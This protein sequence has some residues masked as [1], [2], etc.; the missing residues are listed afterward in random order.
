[1]KR[2]NFLFCVLLLSTLNV[3]IVRAA[4]P[5]LSV[6]EFPAI[7]EVSFPDGYAVYDSPDV[8]KPATKRVEGPTTAR[9]AAYADVPSGRL[10]LS[11]WSYERKRQGQSYFW[12]FILGSGTPEP[13]TASTTNSSSVSRDSV[14]PCG[15]R[16][17]ALATGYTVV[18]APHAKAKLLK[19]VKQGEKMKLS[20]YLETAD[21]LYFISDWSWDR[22]EK[23]ASA[24]PNWI[25]LPDPESAQSLK[26]ILDA[27]MAEGN[28]AD[29]STD[30]MEGIE[31]LAYPRRQLLKMREARLPEGH[32]ERLAAIYLLFESEKACGNITRAS[33]LARRYLEEGKQSDP[34]GRHREIGMIHFHLRNFREADRH[35]RQEYPKLIPDYW[36]APSA[37][38]LVIARLRSGGLPEDALVTAYEQRILSESPSNFPHLEEIYRETGHEQKAARLVVSAASALDR[39]KKSMEAAAEH[40]EV[41]PRELWK[42]A[43]AYQAAGRETEFKEML[44]VAGSTKWNPDDQETT[45]DRFDQ[46][47]PL[48]CLAL[49]AERQGLKK[50]QTAIAAAGMDFTFWRKD[51]LEHAGNI[52]DL[53]GFMEFA[54]GLGESVTKRAVLDKVVATL[55]PDRFIVSYDYDQE[56]MDESLHCDLPVLCKDGLS[57]AALAIANK[58]YY[59][60]CH[61]LKSRLSRL[62]AEMPA[63]KALVEKLKESDPWEKQDEIFDALRKIAGANSRWLRDEV[64]TLAEVQKT[65]GPGTALVDFVRVPTSRYSAVVVTHAG[66][67]VFLDLGEADPINELIR[68]YREIITRDPKRPGDVVAFEQICRDLHRLLAAPVEKAIVPGITDLVI[69][70]DDQLH[71]LSFATLLGETGSMWV[72]SR[73]ICYVASSRDLVRSPRRNEA[74]RS[75]LLIGNPNYMAN[76]PLLALGRASEGRST[77]EFLLAQND[78]SASRGALEG[79]RLGALPGTTGEVAQLRT[80]FEEQQITVETWMGAHADEGRLSGIKGP[81]IL[82]LATHGF[83]FNELSRGRAG[84]LEKEFIASP[85]ERAGVAVA[86]AQTTIHLWQQGRVPPRAEDGLLMAD[87]AALLNLDGTFLVTLSAC[88]TGI[89]EALSGGGI[90]GLKS[91]LGF[92]GAENTLLTLWPISDDATVALMLDFYR[93]ML[94]GKSPARALAELQQLRLP[95]LRRSK[96]LLEAVYQAGAFT[97]STRAGLW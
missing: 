22:W 71:F 14:V 95:E 38:D 63:A 26:A 96:G 87:E 49:M 40:Q 55:R 36:S 29:I 94:D 4:E 7:K 17:V 93:R 52:D 44:M 46:V 43:L 31:N 28:L 86:G 97:L 34:S 66:T 78:R 59:S 41:S 62:G 27:R 54:A 83:Y 74:L 15:V 37:G 21:G 92:A 53:Q 5:A 50:E 77:S 73:R 12:I 10:F 13:S 69:C 24:T 6:Q 30:E 65:L 90:A 79:I 81:S 91:S 39:L 48:F 64:P 68:R 84:T 80:L 32:P 3:G 57:L 88:E 11:D 18:D 25:R 47:S 2:I 33:D 56:K 82:H 89:G 16:E 60:E 75:A 67:P 58:N 51:N 23:E 72:E 20:G 35:W 42:R 85:S 1:M 70:P 45:L 61:A 76:G 19:I 9:V 8:S